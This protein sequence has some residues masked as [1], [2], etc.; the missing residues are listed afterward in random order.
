MGRGHVIDSPSGCEDG[1]TPGN[2]TTAVTVSYITLKFTEKNNNKKKLT[3]TYVESVELQVT[4]T[5]QC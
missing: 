1:S 2:W 3:E 5:A 4:A